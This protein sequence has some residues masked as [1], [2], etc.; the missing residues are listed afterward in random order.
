MK[1]L[2]L[3]IMVFV[4]GMN[5]NASDLS[6]RKNYGDK[7]PIVLKGYMG[8]DIIIRG[9]EPIEIY[10]QTSMIVIQFN[11]SL[12]ELNIYIE[13]ENGNIVYSSSTNTSSRLVN[14][15]PI[16]N[17]QVG[18]YTIIIEGDNGSAEANF[19]IE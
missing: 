10:Q 15:I 18:N 8:E 12:G 14:M 5:M 7:L 13:D 6:V 4:F 9:E 19:R 1:K 17:L 2:L 3:T 11:A 16:G